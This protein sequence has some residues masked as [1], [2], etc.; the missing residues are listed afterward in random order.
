MVAGEEVAGE[1]DV[2]GR[3]DEGLQLSSCANPVFP[4]ERCGIIRSEL[5]PI[6]DLT[7]TLALALRRRAENKLGKFCS[8]NP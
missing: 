2:E 1:D 4:V 6:F 3:E 7:L 5:I 8:F